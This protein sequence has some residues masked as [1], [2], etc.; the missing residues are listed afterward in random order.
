LFDAVDTETNE[1][2][3]IL[4]ADEKRVEELRALGHAGRLA[5]SATGEA[6]L[7]KAG[8]LRTWHFAHTAGSTCP[9]V[10]DPRNLARARA[11]FGSWLASKRA[12][13]T[14][15]RDARIELARTVPGLE[16]HALSCW[17]EHEKGRFGIWV[18]SGPFKPGSYQHIR[19]ALRAHGGDIIF[20]VLSPAKERI[21][22]SAH[23]V[24]LNPTE[25]HL[26]ARASDLDELAREEMRTSA[27]RILTGSVHLL[28]VESGI[29]T[30]IRSLK[31]VKNPSTFRGL[32]RES[33]LASMLLIPPG[34]GGPKWDLMHPREEAAFRSKFIART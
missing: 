18:Q 33:L 13:S 10:R 19:E 21:G 16:D 31:L 23:T 1:L 29:L 14:V 17:F 5:C 15:F 26:I 12:A 22:W 25:R 4:E 3:F 9:C 2:C 30:T 11:M 27:G 28:D 24:S 7:V 20:V 32:R 8:D 6:L 34:R